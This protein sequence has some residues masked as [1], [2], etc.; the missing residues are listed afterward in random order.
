MDIEK[1]RFPVG[2]PPAYNN[3]H[4]DILDEALSVIEEFPDK[5]KTLVQ[6]TTV[7]QLNWRYRPEGWAVKQV[8]HHCADSHIN[9]FIRFK[10]ALTETTPTIKPYFEDK[11]AE[12]TDAHDDNID[13]SMHI[14]SGLH[15]KWVKL[16]RSLG[17]EQF[18]LE[19]Y[20]PEQQRKISLAE[21]TLFYAWHCRHHLAHIDL[22]LQ[23]KGIYN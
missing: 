19:F 23:S 15:K 3:P 8:V 14:I 2:G 6:N 18:K 11:W 12:L 7:E 21:N 4:P 17:N 10:L 5:L 1:L 20:H 16:L 13:Y 9:S 22:G